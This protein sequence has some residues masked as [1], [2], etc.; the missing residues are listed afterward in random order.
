MNGNWIDLDDMYLGF[1]SLQFV[2]QYK[3]GKK[4]GK[5][6]IKFQTEKD[7]YHYQ[8]I[9][10][11]EYDNNEI[12]IGKWTDLVEIF[13]NV[14][15]TIIQVGFYKNDE[16]EGFWDI[17][18]RVNDNQKFQLMGQENLN[19]KYFLHKILLSQQ[20]KLKL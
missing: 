19:K 16:K 9:G 17:M 11:G 12:R 20:S 5:W 18:K 7:L 6:D 4:V 8:L 2:G 15:E 10:G 13:K 3:N 1:L 14:K